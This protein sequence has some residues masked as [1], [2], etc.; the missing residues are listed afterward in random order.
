MTKCN[1]IHPDRNSN[2]RYFQKSKVHGYYKICSCGAKMY[3]HFSRN[4]TTLLEDAHDEIF[5][6]Q[7]WKDLSQKID[8]KKI[9]ND[10]DIV[11]KV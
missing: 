3:T 1:N 7:F 9:L 8:E 5:E 2:Q 6:R 11:L 10:N 4:F